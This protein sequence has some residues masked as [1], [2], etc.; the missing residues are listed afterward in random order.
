MKKFDFKSI[1]NKIKILLD[2][3][4]L[5]AKIEQDK[6]ILI[7]IIILIITILYLDFSFVL[8]SQL[9]ALKST[10]PKIKSLRQDL[11]NLN[12]DLIEM[13]TQRPEAGF[14]EAEIKRLASRTEVP[15]IIEEIS[16]LAN[17][18]KIKIFYITPVR[19]LSTKKTSRGYSSDKHIIFDLE[20]SGGYY[21]LHR[22]IEGLEEHPVFFEVVA[23]D[24]LGNSKD[25]FKHK[26]NLKI[27]AHF[28]S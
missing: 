26:I 10:V 20:L 5:T 16:R 19:R 6:N 13:Q 23:L 12:S 17:L 24:I 15:W 21:Q 4:V 9:G 22:F 14:T 25:P 18:Q 3:K 1:F 28:S 27:K 2:L 8:K 7:L 11:T